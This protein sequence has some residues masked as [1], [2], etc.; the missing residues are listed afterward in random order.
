MSERAARLGVIVGGILVAV[1]AFMPW[2][3][4]GAFGVTGL[5]GD[6]VFAVV[7]GAILAVLGAAILNAG[8]SAAERIGILVL[9][10]AAFGLYA[11]E[12]YNLSQRLEPGSIITLSVGTGIY[13]GA[14]GGLWSLLVS[15]A[16]G[17]KAEPPASP[18]T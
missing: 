8:P 1:A 3:S 5:Q 13:V 2:A 18:P 14:L 15:N 11:F 4:V 9:S 12:W 7:I 17:K 16:I 10:A 6:G